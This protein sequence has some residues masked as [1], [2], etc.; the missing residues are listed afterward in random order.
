MQS[1]CPHFKMPVR[2]SL[3]NKI[4]CEAN[5]MSQASTHFLLL[6]RYKHRLACSMSRRCRI[7]YFRIRLWGTCE[8]TQLS[9]LKSVEM[10][11]VAF[12][13]GEQLG[14]LATVP[15][16]CGG[17]VEHSH[18]PFSPAAI[19]LKFL[20]SVLAALHERGNSGYEWREARS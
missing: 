19:R 16:L 7:E 9:A 17:K 12:L 14:I 20:G 15:S 8:P 11:S 13:K 1:Q 4:A 10:R 3:G 2:V 18:D 6:I 5:V